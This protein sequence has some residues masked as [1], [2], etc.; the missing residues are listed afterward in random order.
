MLNVHGFRVI[1]VNTLENN[2]IVERLLLQIHTQARARTCLLYTQTKTFILL[3]YSFLL[4]F[5]LLQP[6]LHCYYLFRLQYLRKLYLKLP[7]CISLVDGILIS[8]TRLED[9]ATDR[10]RNI[11]CGKIKVMKSRSVRHVHFGHTCITCL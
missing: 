8:A 11:S 9:I 3:S 7:C 1:I 10:L 4:I 5:Y 6:P 2:T